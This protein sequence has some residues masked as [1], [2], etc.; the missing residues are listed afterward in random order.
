MNRNVLAAD[1][2]AGVRLGLGF[3]PKGAGCEVIS[4]VGGRDAGTTGWSDKPFNPDQLL[5]GNK[6]VLR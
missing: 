5:V 4:T 6:K 2:S 1:N 3:T